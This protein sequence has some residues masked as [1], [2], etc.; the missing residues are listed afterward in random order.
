VLL[1][2]GGIGGSIG[3]SCCRCCLALVHLLMLQQ[4]VVTVEVLFAGREIA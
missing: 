3:V 1:R 2:D 4:V